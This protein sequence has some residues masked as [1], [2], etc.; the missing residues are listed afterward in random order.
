MGMNDVGGVRRTDTEY[1]TKFPH[2]KSNFIRKNW[3]LE[4]SRTDGCYI[5]ECQFSRK[6]RCRQVVL[7]SFLNMSTLYIQYK[8]ILLFHFCVTL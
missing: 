8:L 6:E 7:F 2:T 3:M 1:Q 5:I 4:D